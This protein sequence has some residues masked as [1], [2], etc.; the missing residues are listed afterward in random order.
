MSLSFHA[1]KGLSTLAHVNKQAQVREPV[2]RSLRLH[3]P[4]C[5]L[6]GSRSIYV[7]VSELFLDGSTKQALPLRVVVAGCFAPQNEDSASA[8]PRRYVQR[9]LNHRSVNV[10]PIRVMA[11]TANP[12]VTRFAISSVCHKSCRTIS[13]SRAENFSGFS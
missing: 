9:E 3:L 2:S 12:F 11:S 10:A 4:T 13:S 6:G 7:V 1:G 8:R 5:N